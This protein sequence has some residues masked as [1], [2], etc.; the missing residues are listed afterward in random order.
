MIYFY[1]SR[2]S[3][4]KRAQAVDKIIDIDKVSSFLSKSTIVTQEFGTKVN[5]NIL[6]FMKIKKY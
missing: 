2:K 5:N 3:H 4:I 6:Y 1:F